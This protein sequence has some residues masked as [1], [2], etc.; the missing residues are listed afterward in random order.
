MDNLQNMDID[1]I[2]RYFLKERNLNELDD[3]YNF[4]NNHSNNN[5][6]DI[7]K[8][9]NSLEYENEELSKSK[10]E[11]SKN[12]SSNDLKDLFDKIDQTVQKQDWNKLP[13]YIQND[14]IREYVNIQ[15]NILDKN[16]YYKS[17]LE[18]IK[19]KSIKKKDIIYNKEL[20]IIETI[21]E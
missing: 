7:I 14:K 20:C 1:E 18:Q 10:S 16:K 15:E 21:N 4:L 17:L 12:K 11:L 6:S 13:N 5:Y 19:L 8:I 2:Q 3:I 9:K